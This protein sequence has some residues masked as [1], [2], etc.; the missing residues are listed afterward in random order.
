MEETTGIFS[1]KFS[2]SEE[3]EDDEFSSSEE[4]DADNKMTNANDSKPFKVS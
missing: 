2:S 1:Y 3:E 4:E